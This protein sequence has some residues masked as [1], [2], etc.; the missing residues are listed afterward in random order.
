MRAVAARGEDTIVSGCDRLGHTAFHR[1]FPTSQLDSGLDALFQLPL[2]E[3][4]AAR[5]ALAA[6]LKKTRQ[7][8]DAERVKAL[9]KPPASAWAV[10]QLFWRHRPLFDRLIEAGARFRAAHAAQLQGEPADFREPLAARG[11]ALTDL[12]RHAA[13]ILREAGHQPT[14]ALMRRLTLTLEAVSAVETPANG[15]RPG[16][17]TRDVDPPGFDSLAALVPRVVSAPKIDGTASRVLAFDR[18]S[19]PAVAATPET[20]ETRREA[21]KA[22]RSAR[23]A[24]ADAVEVAQVVVRQA[25]TAL[26]AAEEQV[27]RAA[28]RVKEHEAV[29]LAAEQAL[30]QASKAAD[31]ARQEARQLAALAAE[32]ATALAE[33]ER[34]VELAA[35]ELSRLERESARS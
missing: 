16:R 31:T 34:G 35:S 32:A 29:R 7:A 12:T 17:L 26:T 28:A 3:F 18:P 2:H 22:R 25:R 14:P 4:T 5:N 15:A 23:K 10:N 30:D 20:T 19:P 8:D 21:E 13:A 33:A 11:R 9:A 6:H 27:R 24:A 1:G